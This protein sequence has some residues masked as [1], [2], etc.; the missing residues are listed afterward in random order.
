VMLRDRDNRGL[1]CGMVDVKEML[2]LLQGHGQCSPVGT[3]GSGI[4]VAWAAIP[5]AVTVKCPAT[6]RILTVRSP[7]K[8]QPLTA[9]LPPQ[10]ACVTG[11]NKMSCTHVRWG[12]R[13]RW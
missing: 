6:S 7:S 12:K 5:S 2:S 11:S 1:Q 8:P 13:R 3:T 10:V 9:V 4:K